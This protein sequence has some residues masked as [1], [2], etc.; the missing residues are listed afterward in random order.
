MTA[1]P[2]T[3]LHKQMEAQGRTTTDWDSLRKDIPT[4]KFKH[5]SHEDALAARKE[6]MESF[7]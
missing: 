2:G 6:I 3:V 7:C 4:T 1:W 5:Y